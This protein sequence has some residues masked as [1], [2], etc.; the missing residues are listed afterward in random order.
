MF[1]VTF[2]PGP[3]QLSPETRDDIVEALQL[4]IPELSHRS[5]DFTALSERTLAGLRTFFGIPLDYRIFYQSSATEAI[6]TLV[7][8]CTTKQSFHI[9]NGN[10]SDLFAKVAEAN[11][12]EAV[13]HSSP[14]GTVADTGTLTVPADAELLSIAYNETSTGAMCDDADIGRLRT[15]HPEKLLCVD[16][17]SIAGMKAL[18]IASADAWLFSVQKGFGLPSGLGILIVSP[19]VMERAAMLRSHGHASGY[20]S[21][22]DMA[23]M[24]KKN[25]QTIH[26]PN[27]LAIHLLGKQLER[28][29]ANGGVAPIEESLRRKA[30]MLYAAVEK[31]PNL[32]CFVQESKNRSISVACI[33]GSA[34]TIAALHERAI[35]ADLLLGKGYGKI[36]ETT[37]R[38]ATFPAIPESAIAR[39]ADLLTQ[40][41]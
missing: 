20:F 23:A 1:T 8:Q 13:R 28:W 10:F 3:S 27:V 14:W 30:A 2:N 26:T 37:L 24:M 4:R 12:R 5:K 19:R 16:I 21:L 22:A 25:A 15:A 32:R 18:S 11:G 38:I 9:V 34:K 29:N 41:S 35:A 31:N 40:A 17:T 39:A 36:K 7:R 6:E 33:E